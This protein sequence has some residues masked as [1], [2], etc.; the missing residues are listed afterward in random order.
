MAQPPVFLSLQKFIRK[1][2]RNFAESGIPDKGKKNEKSKKKSEP[3]LS[4]RSKAL[5]NKALALEREPEEI[6]QSGMRKK[7]KGRIKRKLNR[8]I[9]EKRGKRRGRI[10]R[11]YYHENKVLLRKN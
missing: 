8:M 6:L 1:I 4:Q 5:W 10:S 2:I 3:G 7:I 11:L 9:N